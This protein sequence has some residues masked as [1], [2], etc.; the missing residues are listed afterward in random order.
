M[1]VLILTAA[2]TVPF[3]FV[4]DLAKQLA[5][6]GGLSVVA[7][8]VAWLIA[9][10]LD[11]RGRELVDADR[12]Y[13]DAER[14]YRDLTEGL[15]LVPWVYDVGDRNETRLVGRQIE[16]LVGYPREEW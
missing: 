13:R 6:A 16:D 12:K 7:A 15:P 2:I 8:A 3:F 14:K 9:Q 1:A 10:R 5:I 4:T 11:R